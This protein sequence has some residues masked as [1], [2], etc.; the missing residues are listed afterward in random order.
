VVEDVVNPRGPYRLSLMVRSGRW[1]APLP[2]GFARAW[3][4]GDGRVVVHAPDDVALELARFM[5]A[6]DDDTTEF[7]ARFGRDA[8]LGPS[9][10]AF[11]GYRPLRL[12]TVTHA[13]MRAVVGQLIESRRARTIERSILRHL[14]SPVATR[15]ALAQL[16]P[17]DLRRHG[18]AQH[19]SSTLA[20]IVRGVDLE[21]LRDL[22]GEAAV[23][24]LA[25]ER[26][27]GPWS[28]GVVALEGLGRYDHGLV[29]DLAL[30]KLAASL[31]GRWPETWETHALLEPYA[32]WEGLAGE[33]LLLGWSRGLVSGADRDVA[34]RTRMRTR[35]AA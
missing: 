33:V 3:Q 29:G 24:R 2:T 18:L 21:R 34:R 13:A 4:R 8:L 5:L 6:L 12:A 31:W 20:R 23:T 32:G 11:V 28:I 15:E 30:V 16:S 27:I 1:T 9:A 10:R 17:L 35:R 25:R 19:R 14:G 7:H 26:G 22:P